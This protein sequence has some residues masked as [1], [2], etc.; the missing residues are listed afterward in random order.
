M[1]VTTLATFSWLLIP[2]VRMILRRRVNRVI[3]DVNTRLQIEL[4]PFQ[5]TRRQT[6]IDR[7]VYDPEVVQTLNEEAHRSGDTREALAA[8]VAH[9]AREIVP[10][11]NAYLYFR[12]G[13]WLARGITRRLYRVRIA[14]LDDARF[15]DI[16]PQATVVFVINHRSNM[17]YVLLSCLVAERTA[18]SYAVGE[19][20]RVWPLQS[21]RRLRGGT[22]RTRRWCRRRT[23]A[24]ATC[25]R[26]PEAA[27]SRR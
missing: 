21:R 2:S 26:R 13:Y 16:D 11:F 14:Q 22:A 12:L 24:R 15:A 18:L 23:R 7:L 10:A 25:C 27:C 3:D 4:R 20:A 6:L 5:L 19:W 1:L 17:D 8:R 9:Y